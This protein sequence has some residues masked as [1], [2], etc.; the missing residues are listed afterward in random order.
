MPAILIE[1]GFMTNAV[2]M[3]K[4]KKSAYQ[5]SIAQGIAQGIQEYLVSQGKAIQQ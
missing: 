4:I 5:K 3:E 2:E 1:G